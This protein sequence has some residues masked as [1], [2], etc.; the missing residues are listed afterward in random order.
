MVPRNLQKTESL[1]GF[2]AIFSAVLLYKFYES[3]LNKI[4]DVRVIVFISN[5]M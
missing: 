5:F 1:C 3:N 2:Q 4:H